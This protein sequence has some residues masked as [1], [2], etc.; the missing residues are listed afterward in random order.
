VLEEN[1]QTALGG[2]FWIIMGRNSFQRPHHEAV[3]LLHNVMDIH[4]GD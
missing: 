4:L 2:G 1:R 3:H